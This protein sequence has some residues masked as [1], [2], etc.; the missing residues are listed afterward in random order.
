MRHRKQTRLRALLLMWAVVSLFFQSGGALQFS[1]HSIGGDQ[2]LSRRELSAHEM[3][4]DVIAAR[5]QS[6]SLKVCENKRT[7]FDQAIAASAPKLVLLS[8]R[9]APVLTLSRRHSSAP[10]SLPTGRAPPRLA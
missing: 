7:Q 5:G 10:A 8:A 3:P 6:F 9:T 4:R 2:P 1:S